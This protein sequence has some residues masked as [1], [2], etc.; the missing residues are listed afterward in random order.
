MNI[1]I[2]NVDIYQSPIPLKEP[3][4]ISLGPMHDAQNVVIV[5]HT[6]Q[7]ISG[8]GECSPFM[9]INGESMETCYV[10]AQ[11][12]AK[13]LKGKDPSD[14]E[15]CH[16]EMD[17]LIYGNSSIKSAFDMALY[18]IAAQQ[19]G[20]PLYK[21]LGGENNKTIQ[22]DYTISLTNPEKMAADAMDIVKQGFEIIKVKLGHSKEQD[23]ESIRQI[24]EAIGYNI[25]LR[26]DANQGWTAEE[27]PE[28]LEAL[29]PFNIQHCEEPIPR[30][31]FMK[32][33]EI[34]KN[35]PIPIMADETCCDHID[36]ERLI[37]LDACH[38]IN[39]KL[40]K[41]SGIFKALKIIKLAEAAS[42]EVQVGGFLETRLGFTASAHLALASKNIVYFDFDTPLMMT[43]DPVVGGILYDKKGVV[44]LPET[45][46]LGAKIRANFLAG[47][48]KTVV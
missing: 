1:S 30:W 36:A 26:I 2:T 42:M 32:L 29:A 48:K 47:L 25:P 40:S 16:K 7:G 4:V 44:T 8:Y 20:V 3:F 10:V 5:I 41:S 39:I 38:Q 21:F 45:P 33:P 43:E 19:A 22:I 31:D 14:I 6:N 11:Y 28:I 13:V 17:R 46:G 27:T 9:T 34:S 23:V 18:D 35:S 37:K 24:R 12:L 15:N